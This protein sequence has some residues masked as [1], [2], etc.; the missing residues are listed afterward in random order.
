MKPSCSLHGLWCLC[1]SLFNP[2]STSTSSEE[3]NA[4]E[5]PVE[6]KGITMF[7]TIDP[8]LWLCLCYMSLG[9]FRAR[10]LVR[11]AHS[12]NADLKTLIR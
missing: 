6:V 1:L 2:K 11:S 9:G 10:E 4:R 12:C 5:I 8:K 7:I 3:I